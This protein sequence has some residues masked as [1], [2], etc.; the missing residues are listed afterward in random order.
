MKLVSS[1]VAP[2]IEEYLGLIETFLVN[3]WCITQDKMVFDCCRNA[4][5]NCGIDE[6][7]K[8]SPILAEQAEKG[9]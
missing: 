8:S 9:E 3:S 6:T 5:C 4:L 1:D 2:S 7:L